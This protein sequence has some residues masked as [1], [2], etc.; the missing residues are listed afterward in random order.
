ML[1][2]YPNVRVSIHVLLKI[3]KLILYKENVHI[4]F[5]KKDLKNKILII[6]FNLKISSISF[7]TIYY[8]LLKQKKKKWYSN[9]S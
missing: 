3:I 4:V 5:R 7:L 8:S 9:L 6:S 1:Y 2:C